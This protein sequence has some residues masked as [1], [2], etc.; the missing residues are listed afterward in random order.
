MRTLEIHTKKDIQKNEFLHYFNE[1]DIVGGINS[2]APGEWCL[3]DF[4]DMKFIG[5]VNSFSKSS[6][7]IVAFMSS[8]K[9]P[10]EL[11]GELIKK[12]ITKR[13]KYTTYQDSARLIYGEADSLPGLVCDEY[14][15]VIVLQINRAGLDLHREFIR[16]SIEELCNKK[17]AIYDNSKERQKEGLPDFN[18]DELPDEIEIEDMGLKYSLNKDQFQKNGYYYDH[19]EN[20]QSLEEFIK[21][22]KNKPKKGLDLFSYLGSWGFHCLKAGVESVTFV[23]QA[24][25]RE[26]IEKTALKN[27]I[28]AARVSFIRRDVFKKLDEYKQEG[29]KFDIVVSDPPA[30]AKSFKAKKAAI[31]GYDKLHSKI[32]D[33]IANEGYIVA[34]SCTKYVTMEELDQSFNK[35]AMKRGY[36]VNL[37]EIG[38]QGYDHPMKSLKSRN[39]YIKYLLYYTEKK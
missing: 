3:F 10:T 25:M 30:F 8:S 11:L 22:L 17:V 37:L 20:R 2:C 21:S 1:S 4:R 35:A 24:E 12:A 15:N 27:E 36:N 5:F 32:F 38:K 23:D 9:S 28:D 19:R 39:N 7:S 31:S 29:M 16:K 6:D 14:K 33:V 34:A 18:L 26:N 13:H